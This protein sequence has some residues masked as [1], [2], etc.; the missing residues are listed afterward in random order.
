M[1][2]LFH[3][4]RI[5]FILTFFCWIPGI[6]YILCYAQIPLEPGDYR[7]IASGD[8]DN[9]AIWETWNGGQWVPANQKPNL[10]NN[11]FIDQSH[12]VRLRENE[13]AKDLYLF[14][15]ADPG[16]KLNLQ[17]FELHLYGA[18]RGLRKE[19]NEFFMN[20][21]SS[22]LTDWIYP[23]TG[24]IVFKGSS[25]TVVDRASWSA[26]NQNSRYTVVFDPDQ[27]AT[28]VVNSAFKASAFII[29]SGTV[30]QTVNTI[31]IPACST[32]S[33]NTQ[34]IFNGGGPYGDLIIEAGGTLISDC[35]APLEQLLRRSASA[36]AS[37]FHLKPG[38]T[39]ILN[40][41][42]P[43][44]EAAHL[45]LEGSV[46]YNSNSGTQQMLQKTFDSSEEPQIYHD[47]I[48]RG[49]SVKVLKE[50]ISLTGNLINEASGNILKENTIFQFLGQIDQ[51]ISGWEM[52]F[53]SW[54]VDKPSG[55]IILNDDLRILGTFQMRN[56][57]IDFN[58]FDFLL[59]QS[60]TGGLDY[61]GGS[62]FNLH[63]F[64]YFNLPFDLGEKNA[65][66]PFEDAYQG[67]IRK[68]QLLGEAPGGD[69]VIRFVEI[70]GANWEPNF[71][72]NDGTPILYQLN[73]FFEFS[74]SHQ[75]ST[76]LEMRI[77]AQNL[78]VDDVDDLRLVSNGKAAPG[79]HI[80]GL[81]PNL[82]WARRS[83]EFA[84]LNGQSF[85]VG[86]F[87]QLSILP[88][89]WLDQKAVWEKGR[90]RISWSTGFERKN[91]KFIIYRSFGHTE[92]FEPIAEL[93]S[94]GDQEG[95]QEYNFEY[96]ESIPDERV[97]FQIEQVD[98]DGQSTL[99]RVFRLE[100]WKLPKDYSLNLWPNPYREGP[101]FLKL[102][103]AWHM[104]NLFLEIL[105]TKGKFKYEG[106]FNPNLLPELMGKLPEGLYLLR[107][108]D[109]VNVAQLRWI[110]GK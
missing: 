87:R 106:K 37:L 85:T 10:N 53:A 78:I 35:S 34:T 99:S 41:N 104:E 107:L 102:G 76:N 44:L 68:I 18:L 42:L 108:N 32:F 15:A 63:R 7:S 26:N 50:S 75:S 74:T 52:G 67:G 49:N 69:I 23:E 14:S 31:G 9:P 4:A 56:G 46:I 30:H 22:L 81:D 66:F 101:V 17:N 25:R 60:G 8:F 110:K 13:S 19:G 6:F 94:Q 59:N 91:E 28:L 58:G 36:P 5:Y 43:R 82:L 79:S 109:G 62:W 39:L 47:L 70:P 27:G 86:S 92:S 21:V 57:Q 1:E 61:E 64:H 3:S 65:T 11:L 54:T 77:S 90:I 20:S 80:P 45:L 97:F 71:N 98:L 55:R 88:V 2:T 73:S 12:E 16:R 40:G 96:K 84:D 105:D 103:S 83:L 95:K 38:A 93:P 100:G 29:L 48:F 51:E 24:K 72:D 89:S 33:F